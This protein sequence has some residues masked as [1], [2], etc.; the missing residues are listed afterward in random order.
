MSG[1]ISLP[2]PDIDVVLP[3][4]TPVVLKNGILSKRS[5]NRKTGIFSFN[6][7]VWQDR[8]ITVF[9][10]YV[11]YAL[12]DGTPKDTV[13]L[14][15]TSIVENVEI[16]NKSFAFKIVTGENSLILN[17]ISEAARRDWVAAI[18]G[19]VCPVTRDR[20]SKA[21]LQAVIDAKKRLY[22][23][24]CQP[25][26]CDKKINQE[27]KYKERYI[28]IEP[29]CF[30]FHWH[31]NPDYTFKSKGLHLIEHVSGVEVKSANN[32]S[33]MLADVKQ[34]QFP[35]GIFSSR[36]E[37]VDLW[38]A[39]PA[40]CALFVSHINELRLMYVPPAVESEK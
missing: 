15:P 33:L 25:I 34:P 22:E 37:S 6:A 24:T 5:R 13:P 29:D 4:S 2:T 3:S 11:A 26:K 17:C 35:S 31:K 38:F 32:F 27:L 1:A 10:D 36:V 12:V 39:D 9:H 14:L 40:M 18:N 30:E 28:W 20:R 8:Q 7:T 16:D 23:P 19:A 21:D